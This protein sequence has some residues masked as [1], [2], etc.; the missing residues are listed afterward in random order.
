MRLFLALAGEQHTAKMSVQDQ[1]NPERAPH[2]DQCPDHHAFSGLG[3]FLLDRLQTH[4][5]F[6]RQGR[7]RRQPRPLRRG[8]IVFLVRYDSTEAI[9]LTG[10]PGAI[11]GKF[12]PN[13]ETIGLTTGQQGL[14]RFAQQIPLAIAGYGGA[15]H[16]HR[17]PVSFRGLPPN[18][19]GFPR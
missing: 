3:E 5:Q 14:Y 8:R 18:P 15:S 12:S 4:Q 6:L 11:G 19:H 13:T 9:D 17:V 1:G 7:L 16:T 2:F 10:I